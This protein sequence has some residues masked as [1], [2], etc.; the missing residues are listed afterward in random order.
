MLHN[1]AESGHEAVEQVDGKLQPDEDPD[2]RDVM[3]AAKNGMYHA[4]DKLFAQWAGLDSPGASIAI[5]QNGKIIYSQGYGAANLEYGVPNSPA[6]VFPLGSVSKQFTAFEAG[7][8]F[9]TLV[10]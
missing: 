7:L 5:I 2:Q 1:V 3:V 4:V 8:Q 6:T 10:A 9:N